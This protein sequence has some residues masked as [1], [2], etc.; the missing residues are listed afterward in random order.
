MPKQAMG[1]YKLNALAFDST[2]IRFDLEHHPLD[3]NLLKYAK[4]RSKH[5]VKYAWDAIWA[6]TA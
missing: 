6:I 4:K 2:A 5:V 3:I 1:S